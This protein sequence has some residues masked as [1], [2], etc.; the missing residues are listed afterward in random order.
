MFILM[1]LSLPLLAPT[2]SVGVPY[3]FFSFHVFLFGGDSRS[4]IR[5]ACREHKSLTGCHTS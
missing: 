3:E 5:V 2:G 1:A 4:L